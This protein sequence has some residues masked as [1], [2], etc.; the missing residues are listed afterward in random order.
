LRNNKFKSY[1]CDH[2]IENDF[3]DCHFNLINFI[4]IAI[5]F[6]TVIII[7]FVVVMIKKIG[8]KNEK[9]DEET[10]ELAIKIED[11]N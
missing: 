2:E 10:D 9:N 3:P 4:F 8:K 1:P 7:C 5:P 6:V 11:H